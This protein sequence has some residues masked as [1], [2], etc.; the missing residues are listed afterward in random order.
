MTIAGT[1][2][3]LVTHASCCHPIPGDNIIGIMTSGKGL[4]VHRS[5]C[6]NSK[7]IMRH[8]D[9]YFHLAWS[10]ATKG[11]FQVMVKMETRNQPG[12]LASVSNIIAEHKSN[13]NNLQVDRQPH[14]T[15]SMS[16]IIE[17]T[18]RRHLAGIMRQL[19]REKS[20]INLSRA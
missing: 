13:I 18:G 10:E 20:V 16:F 8:P 4:V 7:E 17:V 6:S 9:K 19:H 3:L 15:S 12:V 5:N 11:K 2:R 14:N 1:E